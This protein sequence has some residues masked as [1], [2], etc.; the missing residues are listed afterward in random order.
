[1]LLKQPIKFIVQ[2][3]VTSRRLQGRTTHA[4]ENNAIIKFSPQSFVCAI[5][6]PITMK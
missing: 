1:M 6:Q 3:Y 4:N 5:T 2:T